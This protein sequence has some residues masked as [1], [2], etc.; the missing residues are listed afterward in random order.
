[1]EGK[2]RP[3]TE[4]KYRHGAVSDFSPADFELMQSIRAKRSDTG[5][6]PATGDSAPPTAKA[7]AAAKKKGKKGKEDAPEAATAATSGTPE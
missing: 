4:A 1:M 2:Q 3:K 6:A 5:V 7:K